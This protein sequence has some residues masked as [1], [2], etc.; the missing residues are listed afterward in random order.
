MKKAVY[1]AL[2]IGMISCQK[3]GDTYEGRYVGIQH[4][5]KGIYEREVGV[6]INEYHA[7]QKVYG[8]FIDMR[9]VQIAD[10]GEFAFLDNPF[11]EYE[12][13][14]QG[15]FNGGSLSFEYYDAEGAIS[16]SGKWNDNLGN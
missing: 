12:E 8:D 15:S 2:L 5:S 11:T 6:Q 1:A 16:F 7:K 10:N 3:T 9:L 4:D 13:H 14:G